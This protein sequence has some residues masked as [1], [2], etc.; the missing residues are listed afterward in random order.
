MGAR[1]DQKFEGQASLELDQAQAKGQA[2]ITYANF[3]N[4]VQ[5]AMGSQKDPAKDP[6]V[7]TACSAA[8]KAEAAA[9]M[10]G[11]ELRQSVDLAASLGLI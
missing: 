10:L 9:A 3:K 7:A 4:A 5:A 6:S 1:A 2:D 11:V 8:L